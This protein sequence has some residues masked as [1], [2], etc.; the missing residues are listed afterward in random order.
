MVEND[1]MSRLATRVEKESSDGIKKPK[2][3]TMMFIAYRI[4]VK[5]ENIL[6]HKT[7]IDFFAICLL[8]FMDVSSGFEVNL[9][10][11]DRIGLNHKR[12]SHMPSKIK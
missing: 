4:I 8:S 1:G 5:I 10:L 7:N 11:A 2:E 6:K 12:R 3:T 9:S